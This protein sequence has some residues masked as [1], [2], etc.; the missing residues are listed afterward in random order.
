MTSSASAS[1][2]APR[3]RRGRPARRS[4]PSAS[5]GRVAADRGGTHA[6]EGLADPGRM[7]RGDVDL[8]RIARHEARH[9]RPPR[10]PRSGSDGAGPLRGAGRGA[11]GRR[12]PASGGPRRTSRPARSTGRARSPAAPR[13]CRSARACRERR[14]CWR[15]SISFQPAPR[16]SS[17]RPPLI[18]A[19]VATTLARLPGGRKVTGETSVP[20]VMLDVS[21]AR[22]ASV[23]H[24]SV[25]GRPA[26]P[27][28]GVVVGSEVRSRSRPARSPGTRA[29][30]S[31]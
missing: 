3:P 17:T 6:T 2:R 20:S 12:P 21:R 16:P 10:R 25:V 31:A 14:P 24:A 22:P 13:A 1:A 7:Y 23:A 15:C 5:P 27:E 4:W 28:A 26:S 9:A 30:I 19:T 29:R 18:S 11:S 8:V